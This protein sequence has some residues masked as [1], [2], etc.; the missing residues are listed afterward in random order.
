MSRA[1]QWLLDM[2]YLVALG[3][4]A[5]LAAIAGAVILP[6]SGINP[7]VWLDALLIIIAIV[8]LGGFG[9]LKGTIIAAFILGFIYSLVSFLIPAGSWLRLPI[10]LLVMV[11]ILVMRP[12]GLF[13]VVFEEEK[14]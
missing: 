14:L 8:V 2:V 1:R 10:V 6:V 9:S 11:A 4:S 3:L 13:G 12:E 5:A 7:Y